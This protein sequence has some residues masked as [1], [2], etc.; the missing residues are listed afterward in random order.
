MYRRRRRQREIAFSF[1]SFLDVVANV[2]G[3][4]IRLILVTWVGARS[5]H[6]V[7]AQPTA[8]KPAQQPRTF[9]A[10]PAALPPVHD[11]LELELTQHRQELEQ[12]QE[13]LLEQLRQ[14]QILETV[15]TK[16]NEE[17]SALTAAQQSVAQQADQL[18]HAAKD[19]TNVT[20]RVQLSLAELESRG[21]KL[22]Q[23]LLELE[24]LPP[25]TKILRYHTPVSRPVHADELHFECRQGR[26]SFI[27]IDA[28]LTEVRRSTN[29]Y[30]DQLRTQWSVTG[31]TGPI[32][33]FRLRFTVE[34]EQ[35]LLNGDAGSVPTG[36]GGFRYGLSGW[37]A[38]PIVEIRG[39]TA[40]AALA[41]NSEFHRLID[42]LDPEHAVV[43]LWVYPDSFALYRQLRDYLHEH[44][45]EV[46]GRPLPPGTSI[47]ST[48]QGSASRGQ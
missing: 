25:M 30:V 47:A 2:V 33:A 7:M 23:E 41:A 9:A 6:A 1:D 8:D 39:E 21:K 26:I 24:K 22:S 15:N 32:G 20:Q 3:V 14:C 12:Q 45:I 48:R 38:E 18:E 46:A 16:S 43:T 44:N 40:A 36:Q 10:A 37:V 19:Q 42:N 4:I 31:V 28:F 11:A 35:N 17:V 27:D 34:R 5:Y 13:R 29:D